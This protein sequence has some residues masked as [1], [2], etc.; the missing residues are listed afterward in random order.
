[1]ASTSD[2]D[3]EDGLGSIPPEAANRYGAQRGYPKSC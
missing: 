2:F 1:M 3:S